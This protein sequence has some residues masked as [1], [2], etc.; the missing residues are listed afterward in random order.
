MQEKSSC[1]SGG[2]PF[3]CRSSYALSLSF[4]TT[5]ANRPCSSVIVHSLNIVYLIG[6]SADPLGPHRLVT[7]TGSIAAPHDLLATTLSVPFMKIELAVEE[8]F[9]KSLILFTLRKVTAGL[10]NVSMPTDRL[11]R[12]VYL[13]FCK[14]YIVRWLFW[15]CLP[16]RL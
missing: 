14:N 1:H 5:R 15:H 8:Q 16:H 4:A 3:A 2:Q 12:Q 10:K 6:C 7:V 13:T 9:N 11:D